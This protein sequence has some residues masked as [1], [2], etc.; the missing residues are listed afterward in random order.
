[1]IILSP[2]LLPS[3]TPSINQKE[4]QHLVATLFLLKQKCQNFIKQLGQKDSLQ[5]KQGILF[6]K[7]LFQMIFLR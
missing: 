7:F 3:F 6:Y 2:I 4:Q 5:E 1:M